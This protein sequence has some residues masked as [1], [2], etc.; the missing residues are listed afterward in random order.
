MLEFA[1]SAYPSPVDEIIME[2]QEGLSDGVSKRFPQ[3]HT[4]LSRRDQ[5]LIATLGKMFQEGS[6]RQTLIEALE[7]YEFTELLDA[8]HNGRKLTV[9]MLTAPKYR[10]VLRLGES[11]RPVAYNRVYQEI[12][13]AIAVFRD[14]LA[15]DPDVNR[16]FEN[17]D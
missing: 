11:D 6:Y 2:E 5:I 8:V 17:L 15:E 10:K 3:I 1:H 12:G 13:R 7:A 4:G 16:W 14:R 9:N